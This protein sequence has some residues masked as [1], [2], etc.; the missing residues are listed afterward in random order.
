M[1]L[2]DLERDDYHVPPGFFGE[3]LWENRAS[4]TTHLVL[5]Q[6]EHELFPYSAQEVKHVFSCCVLLWCC[7]LDRMD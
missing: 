4:A 6:L 5:V 1:C 7:A 3:V 2:V